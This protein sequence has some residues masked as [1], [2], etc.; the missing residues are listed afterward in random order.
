MT[1]EEE[2]APTI[3]QLAAQHPDKVDWWSLLRLVMRQALDI[4]QGFTNASHQR[5]FTKMHISSHE[6]K[7]TLPG[8]EHKT[9]LGYITTFVMIS[10]P[11]ER[12]NDVKAVVDA[13]GIHGSFD[14]ESIQDDDL[15]EGFDPSFLANAEVKGRG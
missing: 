4:M 15:P 5:M 3:M 8:D 6:I 14:Q 1:D 7:G 10:D 2:R 13:L 11:G 9:N 12:E